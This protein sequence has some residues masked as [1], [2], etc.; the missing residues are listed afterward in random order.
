MSDYYL[1]HDSAKCIGCLSCEVHCKTNK[2]LPI[3]PRL[4]RVLQV[5]PK[6]VN[7]I[8][9]VDFV[10]MPCYHCDRP[11]CVAAC[12]TG[13]MQKRAKDGIVF[14][15]ETLCVGCKACM[16]ACPWGAPQ[17]NPETGKAVKCDYCMD[18]IDAG[19]KPACVSKCV[20]HCLHF[21]EPA[22]MVDSRRER[23][24]KAMAAIGPEVTLRQPAPVQPQAKPRKKRAVTK[25]E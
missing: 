23:H 4:C 17:W 1:F 9:K 3:G 21:G 7:S 19:L 8:P 11:W 25:S 13:A 16:R 10:F 15:D 24:A 2:K 20:T 5:G 12:P 22:A 14:V 6:M 18:R